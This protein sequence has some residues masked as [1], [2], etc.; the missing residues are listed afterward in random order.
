M[1]L[2]NEGFDS[3]KLSCLKDEGRSDYSA[4]REARRVLVK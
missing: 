1:S 3:N 4:L 2:E